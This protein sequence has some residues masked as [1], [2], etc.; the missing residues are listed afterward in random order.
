MPATPHNASSNSANRREFLKSSSAAV[1]GSALAA[2]LGYARQAHA[3]ANDDTLKI[4][5]IGCGGRGTGAAGQALSTSNNVKLI[6]LADAFPDRIASSLRDLGKD[7]T[8]K[9][10]IDV[11]PDRQFTGFD[12]YQ[13]ALD[14][15]ADLVILATPPGFRPM[16]FAAA[17]KAGKH[18]FTEKPL[19]TDAPG[20]RQILKANEDAQRQELAIGV[21][22]QR[23]HQAGY[24][25][26]MKRLHDGAIGDILATRVYWNGDRPWKHS[27]DEVRQMLNKQDITEMEYQMKN[28]YYFTWLCGD[29]IVEQHIHNIDV[30]NWIKGT[31][32]IKAAGMGGSTRTRGP[33]D[34]EIFDHHCVEFEYPDGSR[35]FSQCRHMKGCDNNVTEH[36]VGTKGTADLNIAGKG[37]VI[38]G[39]GAADWKYSGRGDKDPY[40]VEHDDLQA[41]IRNGTPYNE[42]EYGAASTMTAILGRLATYGGKE[43]T[44]DE[45][46]KSE[47]SL[48]P[49]DYAWDAA[50]PVLPDANGMYPQAVPGITKVV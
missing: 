20:I 7:E 30:S 19:A 34:G 40:Q 28:W 5:L 23:H 1:V 9:S 33:D 48:M 43:V 38:A 13:K 44:W 49:K 50:P 35:M 42:V 6:A 15:G 18:I 41:A 47:I 29:H 2:S 26:A 36:A 37:Y 46:M 24:V 39:S 45:A 10:K 22:L 11:P 4:A 17:V 31:H 32:P 14:A 16:H 27:R 12:A 21:G 8:K 25:E 3:I